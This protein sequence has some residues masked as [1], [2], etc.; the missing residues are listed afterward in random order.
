MGLNIAELRQK[1]EAGSCVNQ[2][3][4][5]ACYF[6]GHEVD[7]DYDEAFRWLSAAAAQGSS[8]AVLH[9]GYM[10]AQ[11]L[12]TTQDVPEAFTA[13]AKPAESSDAFAARIEL[14]RIF[15]RVLID[16]SEARK[17]YLAAVELAHDGEN[18]EELREAKDYI[19]GAR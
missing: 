12:G 5:G 9:L 17:W 16:V 18:S 7:R 13:V 10:Y 4:L 8:R 6:Y 2:C 11:G 19:A 14:G 3:V 15:S 1:A